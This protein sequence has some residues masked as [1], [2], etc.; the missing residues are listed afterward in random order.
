V[1]GEIRLDIQI[2]TVGVEFLGARDILN[3]AETTTIC[4]S[5]SMHY[6]P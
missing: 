2:V 3:I 5:P 6:N 4:Q 1:T